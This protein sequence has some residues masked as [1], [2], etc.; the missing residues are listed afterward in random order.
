MGYAIVGDVLSAGELPVWYVLLV[1]MV[2]LW[3]GYGVPMVLLLLLLASLHSWSAAH[4]ACAHKV[5]HGLHTPAAGHHIH[6][7]WTV[8][9]DG[10]TSQ[11]NCHWTA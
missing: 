1:L 11:H 2:W 9:L 5:F 6:G 10:T 3:C 4:W 8:P 7:V